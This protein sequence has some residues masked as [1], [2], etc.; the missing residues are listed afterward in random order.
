[1]L[2]VYSAEEIYEQAME[3]SNPAV[4]ALSVLAE[5]LADT[6]KSLD[7]QNALLDG[8][9][10]KEWLRQLEEEDDDCRISEARKR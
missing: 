2:T 1:M 6:K 7:Y 10:R 9:R 5:V 4:F 3:Q 8:Q